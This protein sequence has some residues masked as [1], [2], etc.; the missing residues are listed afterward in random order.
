[1]SSRSRGRSLLKH[2]SRQRSP[3]GDEDGG[4][5]S[6]ISSIR[7]KSVCSSILVD[8]EWQRS[9]ELL[10]LM[11][12]QGKISRDD[13]DDLLKKF[14]TDRNFKS[15]DAQRMI[16]AN[17]VKVRKFSENKHKFKVI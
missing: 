11:V 7:P 12:A 2:F 4:G 17:L 10:D 8:K 14:A 5:G 1:M 13:R 9:D 6:R 3:P 16:L 15:G